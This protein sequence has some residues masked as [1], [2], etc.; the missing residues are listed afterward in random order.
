MLTCN[1]KT[2]YGNLCAPNNCRAMSQISSHPHIPQRSRIVWL[3]SGSNNNVSSRKVC[4]PTQ[5]SLSLHSFHWQLF[6]CF[7]C[8]LN[9]GIVGQL[10]GFGWWFTLQCSFSIVYDSQEMG[11]ARELMGRQ[12]NVYLGY[13]VSQQAVQSQHSKSPA[14]LATRLSCVLGTHRI[15]QLEPIWWGPSSSSP[16]W[17]SHISASQKPLAASIQIHFLYF[18]AT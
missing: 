5:L 6:P 2:L 15:H 10:A 3:T 4:A 7:C 9:V 13:L 18:L 16:N 8:L 17:P 12:C 14:Y 1:N 11:V